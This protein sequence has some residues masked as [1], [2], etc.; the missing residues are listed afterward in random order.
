[1]VSLF[2]GFKQSGVLAVLGKELPGIEWR[3][4]VVEF[5]QEMD[6]PENLPDMLR[7]Q[8][9]HAPVTIAYPD[10]YFFLEQLEDCGVFPVEL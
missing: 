8:S 1:L 5:L 10:G 9:L 2:S 4:I 7:R 6:F 3:E